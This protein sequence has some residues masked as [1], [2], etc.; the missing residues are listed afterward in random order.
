MQSRL[1]APLNM[2]QAIF[3]VVIQRVMPNREF[4]DLLREA[5]D[6][7]NGLPAPAP[8]LE[9]AAFFHRTETEL[10]LKSRRVIP[11][12]LLEAGFQFEYENWPAAAQDLVR[13]WKSR[14]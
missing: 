6:V 11:A 3:G 10:L 7:P 14:D 2:G 4:M 5:W 1:E 9:L 13:R 8:L 12:R